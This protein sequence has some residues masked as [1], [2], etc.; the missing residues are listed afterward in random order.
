MMKTLCAGPEGV[1]PPGEQN[2]PDAV[3]KKLIEDG[4]AIALHEKKE[5]V[6]ET[7]AVEPEEKGI[8]GRHKRKR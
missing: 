5:Q 3:A 7:A 4:A 2:V 6:I 1:I 8:A